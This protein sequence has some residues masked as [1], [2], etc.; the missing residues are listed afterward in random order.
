MNLGDL[1]GVLWSAIGR[2]EKGATAVGRGWKISALESFTTC[3]RFKLPSEEF[4][5]NDAGKGPNCA[6]G[7]AATMSCRA[8]NRLYAL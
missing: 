2:A 5:N 3:L 8:G 6:R 7:S 4:A 1:R